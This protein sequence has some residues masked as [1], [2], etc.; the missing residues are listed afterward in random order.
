MLLGPRA[1]CGHHAEPQVLEHGQVRQHAAL[2]GHPAD[3]APDDL[4]RL[5]PRD[6]LSPSFTAPRR[7]RAIPMIDSSVV[8]LPA[9]LRP[10]MVTTSPSRTAIDTP[11]RMWASP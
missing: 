11:W 10:I 5:A 7:A 1:V 3:A 8:V 9:P 6:V 4:V 2:L